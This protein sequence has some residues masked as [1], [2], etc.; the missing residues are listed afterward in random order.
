[1]ST[2]GIIFVPVA[3]GT[4]ISHFKLQPAGQLSHGVVLSE[5]RIRVG[6]ASIHIG[7]EDSKI[8]AKF[9][10]EAEEVDLL[11]TGCSELSKESNEIRHEMNM[12]STTM[13]DLYTRQIAMT[14]QV[15]KILD[16]QE[17]QQG[18][19]V[20]NALL[21]C[22]LLAGNVAVHLINGGTKLDH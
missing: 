14:E 9:I 1:M 3:S 7:D 5:G 20:V 15:R 8:V 22:I 2:V 21:A 13:F 10:I 12:L 16:Y 19:S 11:A 6:A 18:I 4:C 17:V